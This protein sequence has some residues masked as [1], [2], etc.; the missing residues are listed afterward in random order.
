M[1]YLYDA[2]PVALS[3]NENTKYC[4]IIHT[5]LE[6][7]AIHSNFFIKHTVLQMYATRCWDYYL[8]AFQVPDIPQTSIN[9]WC[10]LKFNPD[11]SQS[12]LYMLEEM[13]L[14]KE[15]LSSFFFSWIW[16]RKCEIVPMFQSSVNLSY[17][18]PRT[19]PELCHW[20]TREGRGSPRRRERTERGVREYMKHLQW[21]RYVSCDGSVCTYHWTL[22]WNLIVQKPRRCLEN[23]G[24]NTNK[25]RST[26]FWELSM[27][28]KIT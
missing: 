28:L 14:K 25:W 13:A 18:L 5:I 3:A 6:F 1:N 11:I 19:D 2:Q 4:L 27:I 8:Y 23:K 20:A 10:S 17:S 15:L 9:T 12:S 7:S 26:S 22:M 21:D 24:V 16:L